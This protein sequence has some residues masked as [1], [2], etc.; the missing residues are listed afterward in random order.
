MTMEQLA[1][2]VGQVHLVVVGDGDMS[3][4]RCGQIQRRRRPES[5]GA[6]DQHLGV[7]QALLSFQPDGRQ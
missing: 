1:L 5:S 6:H 2:Q 3:D 4:A 7:Q